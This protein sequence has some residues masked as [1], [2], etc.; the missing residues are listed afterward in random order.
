MRPDRLTTVAAKD[1]ANAMVR[2]HAVC[3]T[4]FKWRH[5]HSTHLNSFDLFPRTNVVVGGVAILATR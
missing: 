5:T 2:E 3:R 4:L 1:H